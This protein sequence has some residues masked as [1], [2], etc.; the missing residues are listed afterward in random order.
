MILRPHLIVVWLAFATFALWGVSN[1][2]AQT[3]VQVVPEQIQLHAFQ[4]EQ[5]VSV[6]ELF[7]DKS[8]SKPLTKDSG[9]TL[10]LDDPQIAELIESAD[11]TWILRA[12][13]SG[14]TILKANVKNT[15]GVEVQGQARVFVASNQGVVDWEF[16]NH[17]QPILSRNG[18]NMGA[19]HGALAGKGGFRLSLRGYDSINDHFNMVK[20]DNGRRVEL[21]QPE[22]SLILL[23]PTGLVEH[24]GGVR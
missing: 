20:Q 22:S 12:K 7:A 24:Q 10:R 19:C 18:C 6:R 4:P 17:V 3:M 21:A 9:L 1:T 2:H 23:K 15:Q 11:G 13:G 8:F 14:S 5:I 16:E